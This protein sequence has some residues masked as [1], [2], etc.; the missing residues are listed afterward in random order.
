MAQSSLY[1]TP[2]LYVMEWIGS[3][4]KRERHK[5]EWIA[6]PSTVENDGSGL[7]IEDKQKHKQNK[8]KKKQRKRLDWW[9]SLEEER[10]RRTE[11][12]RKPRE[13]GRRKRMGKRKR[14]GEEG[15]NIQSGT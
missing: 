4:I 12:N 14:E 3:E 8:N 13:C 2:P 5:N 1:T 10:M 15:K 6:S 9:A 7:K 11:K